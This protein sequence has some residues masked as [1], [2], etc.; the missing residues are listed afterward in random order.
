MKFLPEFSPKEQKNVTKVTDT[1]NFY[2]N[3]DS[4]VYFK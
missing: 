3:I 2:I 1:K 4:K